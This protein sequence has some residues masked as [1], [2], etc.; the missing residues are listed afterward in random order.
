MLR[1]LQI[2]ACC[3][4]LEPARTGQVNLHYRADAC[5][6]VGEND[7]MGSQEDRFFPFRSDEAVGQVV[8][9]KQ[10]SLYS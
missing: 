8:L 10:F 7:G 2:L 5:Q 3:K 9:V 4:G 1:I 6:P